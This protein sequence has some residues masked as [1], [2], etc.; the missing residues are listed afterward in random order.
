MSP[1]TALR[2]L[3]RAQA[4]L[5]KARQLLRQLRTGDGNPDA[6]QNAFRAGYE[7]LRQSHQILAALPAATATEEVLT[8]Q[9]AVERYGT[10]LLVRLRRLLRKDGVDTD[11]DAADDLDD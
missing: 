4:Q 2:E 9:L 11:D 1:G 5:R 10:A 8:R 3:Q 7:S 6:R